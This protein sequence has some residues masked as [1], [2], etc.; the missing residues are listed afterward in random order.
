MRKSYYPVDKLL[1]ACLE[2]AKVKRVRFHDLRHTYGALAMMSGMSI[3]TLKKILGHSNIR[4]TVDTYAHLAPDFIHKE[5][6]QVD[7]GPMDSNVEI[8]A[9]TIPLQ[10][11]GREDH[12]K[13]GV[14]SNLLQ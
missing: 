12:A 9:A 4:T 6:N 7:F 3:L 8:L 13:D 11:G 1:R 14:A 10:S 5:A 2:K